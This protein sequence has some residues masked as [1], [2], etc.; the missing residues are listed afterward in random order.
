M[1]KLKVFLSWSG[2][3]SKAV[4]EALRTWLPDVLQSVDPFLSAEDIEKGAKWR[5]AISGEL[6]E[7]NFAI[8]CLTP[9]N[10]AAPWL[11]FE[12]GALSK[13]AGSSVC[14]YLIDLEPS[15]VKDPLSEFQHTKAA[16][17]DTRKLLG[18]IN[19]KLASPLSEDALS[20]AFEAWWP[21]LDAGLRTLP[22]DATADS[23][24]KNPMEKV[25]EM[26]T[27]ILDRVREQ[28]RVTPVSE[29]SA[30]ASRVASRRDVIRGLRHKVDAACS[31]LDPSL[32]DFRLAQ[33]LLL[34]AGAALDRADL[35]TGLARY[36]EAKLILAGAR[37]AGS[38]RPD[39]STEDAAG[40]S[41][42]GASADEW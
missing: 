2:P 10:L 1:K 26:V 27:E 4:A 20:R 36:G 18:C 15:D 6:A 19:Q 16:K 32:K 7:T 25:F 37:E 14:T 21:T 23:V 17:S 12:A 9:A 5:Q 24:E 41:G 8:I 28:N 38:T 29:G 3:R 13:V 42:Q 39:P 22:V 30:A 11:L 40:P 34:A 35:E 33:S 31:G